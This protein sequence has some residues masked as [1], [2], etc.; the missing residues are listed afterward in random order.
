MFSALPFPATC[1]GVHRQTMVQRLAAPTTIAIATPAADQPREPGKVRGNLIAWVERL[2]SDPGDGEEARHRKAQVVIASILVVPAGLLWGVLYFVFG[3]REAAAIP[4]S[5]SVFTFLDLLFLLRW[6]R[7]AVFRRTQQSLLVALPFALQIALG[8]FVGSSLVI[9]WAFI[10]V[11]M[12][13]LFGSGREAIGWFA[14]FVLAIL[15]AAWLEPSLSVGNRLPHGLVLLFFILNVVAVSSVAFVVVYSFVTDRRKLRELEIAYVNQEMMLR[16][17]EKLAT[18]GTLAAGVAHE[19][20]NPAAAARRASEQLRSAIARLEEAHLRLTE[21][22]VTNDARDALRA[23][24]RHASDAA[25][26][27]LHLD[28]LAR[29]D[30]EAAV[31]DW[32]EHHAVA[33]VWEVAP[34]LVDQDLDPQALSKLAEIIR[35]EALA[36]GL[37]WAASAY[38]VHALLREIG[39]S[40]TRVSDIVSALKGYTHLGQAPVQSVDLHEGIDNTLMVLRHSLD[41]G[42]SVRREYGADVPKLQA[43]GGELNQVWTNLLGNAVDALGG[44]GEITIRT[45]REGE[46]VVVEIEDNG[47]GIPDDI[48]PRI[49]DPFFTTKAPGK[50]TGLG[51][52]ISHSIV[53]QKHSGELRMES[54]PGCTRFTVRLPIVPRETAAPGSR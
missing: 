51:L 17:S 24:E 39:E 46:S 8:G 28:P 13:L 15:A 20:N 50:G 40:S 16:Q 48:G 54:R 42:I 47:P 26:R 21:V 5:Y 53:T 35:G 9:L 41:E 2:V 25:A 44:K 7:Y 30:A 36:A 11:L 52:S 37:T 4:W 14:A 49:F 12:A 1:G 3:E 23:M 34:A 19:L 43:Y 38:R 10:A 32:L 18:L 29:S 45:R 31:E 27:T 33:N 22:D 6:R